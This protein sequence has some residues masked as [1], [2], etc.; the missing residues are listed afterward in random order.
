MIADRLCAYLDSAGLE[1]ILAH[2]ASAIGSMKRH[3]A[4]FTVSK[5]GHRHL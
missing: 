3:K 1:G 4:A 2:P 5:D